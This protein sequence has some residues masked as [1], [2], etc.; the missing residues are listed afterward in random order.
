[1]GLAKIRLHAMMQMLVSLADAL[2]R[3]AVP[4]QLRLF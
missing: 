2:V 4:T 3:V 1:M